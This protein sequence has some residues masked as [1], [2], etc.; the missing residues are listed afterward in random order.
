MLDTKRVNTHI[1]AAFH[2]CGKSTFSKMNQENYNG[3]LYLKSDD[4]N[5]EFYPQNYIEAVEANL[6][7]F[8][9]IL[10]DSHEEIRIGLWNRNISHSLV[11]PE[12]W[13]KDEWITR[14]KE[15]GDSEDFILYMN[16]NWDKMIDSLEKDWNRHKIQLHWKWRF[17]LCPDVVRYIREYLTAS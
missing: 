1:I 10:V 2:G 6:G 8:E 14:F 17:Y 4:F 9:I 5:G 16:D 7:K 3:V 15:R 12:R 11:Y 13:R